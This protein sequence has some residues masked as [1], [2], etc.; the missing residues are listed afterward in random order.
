MLTSYVVEY[1]RSAVGVKVI[2][3]PDQLNDP[4][5][6]GSMEKASSTDVVFIDSLNVTVITVVTGMSVPVGVLSVTV[7]AV[8]SG[9]APVVKSQM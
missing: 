1:A 3:S 6:E 2:V 8:V 4:A 5:T 7:G 9:S